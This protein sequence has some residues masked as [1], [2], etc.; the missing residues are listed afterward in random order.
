MSG[1]GA[2]VKQR[3]VE[4]GLSQ[5]ALAKLA[6]VTQ[7][8]ISN[9]ERGRNKGS[10]YAVQIAAALKCSGPWLASGKGDKAAPPEPGPDIRARVPRISWTAAGKWAEVQDPFPP[11]GEEEWIVTTASVGP[12][13]FALRVVGDSMEPKIPDGATVI[14]DPS[15]T[16]QHG[17]IVLAKRMGEQ[18]A[19]LKQ[20]WYD[21]ATPLLRPLNERYPILDMPS[22]TQIIGVVVQ[23]VLD[24]T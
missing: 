14:I 13:A 8:T 24:F 20:L 11:R 7:E 6:G 3:R 12:N 22:D 10:R 2:R 5:P 9:I 18:A 1:Y 17:S 15:R 19:T 21:G 16:F 4:L 23:M